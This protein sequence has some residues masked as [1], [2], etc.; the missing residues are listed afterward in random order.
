MRFKILLVTNRDKA[1]AADAEMLRE[2]GMLVY[3][4][5][6]SIATEMVGEIVPDVVLVNPNEPDASLTKSYHSLLQQKTDMNIPIIYTLAE[7][8]LYLINIKRRNKIERCT[9]DNII[10]SI[11]TSLTN[12]IAQNK[13][14]SY[15]LPAG[16]YRQRRA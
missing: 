8:E 9:A 7:D 15:S 2:R 11:K 16:N 12:V 4:C 13:L 3:T 14:K 6:S 5:D 1:T 10:D